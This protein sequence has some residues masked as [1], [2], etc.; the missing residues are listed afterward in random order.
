MTDKPRL[1]PDVLTRPVEDELLLYDPNNGETLLLNATAASIIELCNGERDA[2]AIAGIIA[3]LVPG[4]N[5]DEVLRDVGKTLGEL[6]D[7][8]MLEAET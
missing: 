5:H 8:D 4:A 7:K 3:Q 2:A 6:R 1:R